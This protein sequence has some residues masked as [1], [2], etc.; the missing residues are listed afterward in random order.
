MFLGKLG[1]NGQVWF[2]IGVVLAILDPDHRGE[3]LLCAA[4]GPAAL[5]EP[6]LPSSEEP[7]AVSVIANDSTPAH[8]TPGLRRV[9]TMSPSV[10]YLE[11]NSMPGSTVESGL[12]A[13]QAGG[14]DFHFDH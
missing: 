7:N 11:M 8:I 1:E 5:P 14:T 3:W 9:H 6:E 12:A 2:A 10:S 13:A 4:L